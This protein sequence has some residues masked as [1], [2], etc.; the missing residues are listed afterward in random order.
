[1]LGVARQLTF[2]EVAVWLDEFLGRGSIEAP[3][4]LFPSA[5]LRFFIIRAGPNSIWQ[6]Q[7]NPINRV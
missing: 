7:T 1:M 6:F 5:I 3:P 2:L 4:I